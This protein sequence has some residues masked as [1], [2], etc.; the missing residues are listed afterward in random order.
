MGPATSSSS[1]E[2][3]S[4]SAAATLASRV[5]TWRSLASKR[6]FASASAA[7]AAA[8]R[9][10][11][12]SS[13]SSCGYIKRNENVMIGRGEEYS[14]DTPTWLVGVRNVRRMRRRDWSG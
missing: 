14:A 13:A 1:L 7:S 9:A 10:S 12:A 4:A 3:A 6:P 11:R 5:A 2:R 8:A